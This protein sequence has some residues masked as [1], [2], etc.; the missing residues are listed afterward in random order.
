MTLKP[1]AWAGLGISAV[2][3]AAALAAMAFIDLGKADQTASVTGGSLGT[4]GFAL[5]LMAQF[6]GSSD[7]PTTS[8]RPP[9]VDA[10]GAGAIAAGGNI[11]T[12]STGDTTPPTSPPQSPP[13][14]PTSGT[15]GSRG[16]VTASGRGS[17]AA[18]GDIR[19]ASTGN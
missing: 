3:W 5:A 4:I 2:G 19:S 8:T 18:G 1:W 13:T 15:S 9:T 16:N 6:S 7:L 12:A 11:G 17:I 14:P 10:S